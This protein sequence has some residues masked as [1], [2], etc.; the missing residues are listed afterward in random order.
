[1][2]IVSSELLGLAITKFL[3]IFKYQQNPFPTKTKAVSISQTLP[4]I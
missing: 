1:M 2:V 3:N 4:Y